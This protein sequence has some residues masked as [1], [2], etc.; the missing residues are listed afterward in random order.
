M[1]I[2]EGECTMNDDNH[3]FRKLQVTVFFFG[4]IFSL[5]QLLPSNA[6]KDLRIVF[7]DQKQDKGLE[8]SGLW[9]EDTFA[10][11]QIHVRKHHKYS[12]KPHRTEQNGLK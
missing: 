1:N 12:E 10:R 9:Y 7:I 11:Y 5:R 4:E 2:D 3:R 8:N 6:T